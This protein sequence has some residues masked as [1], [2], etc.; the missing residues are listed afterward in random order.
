[1][2]K[3]I[4]LII[5]SFLVLAHVC[6]ADF[7]YS[8]EQ[9]KNYNIKE[10]KI[11]LFPS[12][13]EHQQSSKKQALY[14]EISYDDNGLPTKMDQ[15]QSISFGK[16]KKDTTYY[17]Y[18]ND[19][20]FYSAVLQSI[21]SYRDGNIQSKTEFHYDD[22]SKLIEVSLYWKT[23]LGMSHQYTTHYT[24]NNNAYSEMK[25]LETGRWLS[26]DYNTQPENQVV[27][28]TYEPSWGTNVRHTYQYNDLGQC[29]K[30]LNFDMETDTLYSTVEYFYN[31]AGYMTKIIFMEPDGKVLGEIGYIYDELGK[32]I[33]K[34]DSRM[35]SN[36]ITKY[37]YD[38]D[39][40]LK[41]ETVYRLNGDPKYTF[42][43]E[44]VK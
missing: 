32:L 42:E 15:Y 35:I 38:N 44:Y 18:T 25:H 23:G 12:G 33:E 6:V 4:L 39:G 14:K 29:I 21:T 11:Y 1:M 28:M 3:H 34:T 27:E 19:V 40:L 8:P 41:T 31:A 17:T 16:I 30:K 37:F 5:I 13:V 7:E 36:E 9:I 10:C 26:Q 20:S 24:Y 2:K 43:Y 22:N